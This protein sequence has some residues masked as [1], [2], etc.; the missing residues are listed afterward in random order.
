MNETVSTARVPFRTATWS[1]VLLAVLAV[2]EAVVG[3]WALLVPRGFYD[4]FPL[5]GHPWVALLPPYNEHLLRDFGGLNLGF[6]LMLAVAAVTLDRLLIRTVLAGYL[7]Y[8]VPH[9]TFHLGHLGHFDMVDAVGQVVV[10]ALC[11]LAPAIL[12]FLTRK[13]PGGE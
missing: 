12:L 5:P 4:G 13:A 1:R 7:L 10:L 3:G 8:S 2:T 11:V 9:L 6:G